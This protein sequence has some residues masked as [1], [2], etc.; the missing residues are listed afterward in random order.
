MKHKIKKVILLTSMF[1]LLSS[2]CYSYDVGV[3][4]IL[5]NMVPY[6]S[7]ESSTHDVSYHGGAISV[8]KHI[9]KNQRW[10]FGVSGN[11]LKLSAE[12]DGETIHG[13]MVG[14]DLKFRRDFIPFDPVRLFI[15]FSGGLSY[16]SHDLPDLRSYTIGSF[17]PSVGIIFSIKGTGWSFKYETQGKHRSNPFKSKEFGWNTWDHSVG[18][19]RTF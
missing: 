14:L 6:S 5:G 2:L 18:V 1:V 3:D 7:W 9:D 12:R 17:G 16:L 13:D 19:T 15:G 11:F 4:L 8:G 10:Y